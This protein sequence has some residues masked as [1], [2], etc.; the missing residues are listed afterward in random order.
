LRGLLDD[1]VQVNLPG[2]ALSIEWQGEGQPVM[3]TGPATT[4]YEGQIQL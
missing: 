3:M 4:V 1:T 2:G